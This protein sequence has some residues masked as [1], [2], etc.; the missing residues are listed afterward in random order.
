MVLTEVHHLRLVRQLQ[1][2][3]NDRDLPWIR[4]SSVGVQFDRLRHVD[5]KVLGVIGNSDKYTVMRL[6]VDREDNFQLPTSHSYLYARSTLS[7]AL[8][9]LSCKVPPVYWRHDVDFLECR[10]PHLKT[11]PKCRPESF[12][13]AHNSQVFVQIAVLLKGKGTSSSQTLA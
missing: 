5:S 6:S 1:F 11:T 7:T 2:L 13:L 9:S 12:T 3:K 10:T 4:T 8:V